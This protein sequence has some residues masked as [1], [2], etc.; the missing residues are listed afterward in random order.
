L[1]SLAR[2]PHKK[3]RKVL[4]SVKHRFLYYTNDLGFGPTSYELRSITISNIGS[5]K[6][7]AVPCEGSALPLC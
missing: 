2:L 3:G 6:S 1:F 7:F 5:D 4:S